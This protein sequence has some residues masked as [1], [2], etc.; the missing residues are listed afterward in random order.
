MNDFFDELNKMHQKKYKPETFKEFMAR[1]EKECASIKEINER[2]KKDL[3]EDERKWK[4]K[5]RIRKYYTT[6][7]KQN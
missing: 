3:A 4:I 1:M 2:L 6:E 5:N 7:D